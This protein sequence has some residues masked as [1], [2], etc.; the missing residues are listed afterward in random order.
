MEKRLGGEND[1]ETTIVT[2]IG[3]LV[4]MI[5]LHPEE[6]AGFV[7]NYLEKRKLD[8]G[9]LTWNGRTDRRFIGVC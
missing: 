2:T 6:A 3:S 9:Y 1:D 4:A 5:F 7:E 8:L